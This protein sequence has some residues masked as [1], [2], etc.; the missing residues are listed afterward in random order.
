[1][2]KYMNDFTEIVLTLPRAVDDE[3]AGDIEKESVFVSPAI[4]RII[5]N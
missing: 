5:V 1:M 4:D 2:N 3:V